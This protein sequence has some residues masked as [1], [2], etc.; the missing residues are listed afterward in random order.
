VDRVW[1]EG[2]DQGLADKTT[3]RA[4]KIEYQRKAEADFEIMKNMN[5]E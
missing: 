4:L 3:D 1:E 5:N 2:C